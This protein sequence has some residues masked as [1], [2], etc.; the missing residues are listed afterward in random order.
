MLCL[1]LGS[2]RRT[3]FNTNFDT[4]VTN[5]VAFPNNKLFVAGNLCFY[6]RSILKYPEI[7]KSGST[8]KMVN[9]DERCFKYGPPDFF[10][11]EIL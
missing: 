1:R 10:L 5:S 8:K 6:V 2:G 11:F 9:S 4:N 7:Q 3:I